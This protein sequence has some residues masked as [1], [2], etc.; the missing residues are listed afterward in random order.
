VVGADYSN[1]GR[2]RL[3]AEGRSLRTKDNGFMVKELGSP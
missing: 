3:M 2:F 1:A